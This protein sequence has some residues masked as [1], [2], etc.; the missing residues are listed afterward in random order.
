MSSG[1]G[2]TWEPWW[3][4]NRDPFLNLKAIIHEGDPTLGSDSY[5]LGHVPLA[6]VRDQLKPT[7]GVIHDGIVPA[8]LRVLEK[9]TDNDLVTGALIALAKIGDR[10]GMP[11]GDDSL[12]LRFRKFLQSSN[13][14]IAETAAVSLGILANDSSI[15]PLVDLL[16]DTKRGRELVGQT[17]V[18]W[19]TRAFAAY[20]L[21]LTG[22]YSDDL[23]IRA[24]ILSVLR[25]Q[26][27]GD[28]LSMATPDVGVACLTAMSL[29]WLDVDSSCL[30]LAGRCPDASHCRRGQL[31]W[32]L[33]Y[34]ANPKLNYVM[35]A[36]IPTT[37]ARL[38]QYTAGE[39]QLE[40]MVVVELLGWAR[41]AAKVQRHLRAS[42]IMALGALGTG[43]DRQIDREI[44]NALEEIVGNSRQPEV[45]TLALVSLG[46]VGARKPSRGNVQA[47]AVAK[48]REFL[49]EQFADGRSTD[50]GWSALALSLLESRA[51][52]AGIPP[53]VASARVLRKALAEATSPDQVGAYAIALGVMQDV[54]SEE[55]MLKKL[56]QL[57]DDRSRGHI[58]IGLGLMNSRESIEALRK[59]LKGS[60]YR[61]ALLREA[62]IS[63]GLLGDKNV[64]DDLVDEMQ[65]ST[66]LTGQSAIAA[67]LGSI[68]DAR[69]VAPLLK[70]LEDPEFNV[71]ARA[72]AAVALGIVADK[73]ALPWNSK[74]AVGANYL[75][76]TPTLTDGLG[77]GILDIL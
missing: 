31:E 11:A 55:L 70:M 21:G 44:I 15:E 43:A 23:A 66:S 41:G 47:E 20:G 4:F 28:A 25:G 56:E 37:L 1:S 45:R 61:P 75:A 65:R 29:V 27:E 57:S 76:G 59:L 5:F 53:S 22:Y 40:G 69:S 34:A 49:L 73:E 60:R 58:C 42:A 8:L 16:R 26:L 18:P 33:D 51:R 63:L 10:P 36:H 50:R 35:H 39:P 52:Q 12:V 17:E 77:A 72:F 48:V 6:M 74:I 7:E 24:R 14:E 38:T 67:A 13:Q 9:E 2:A 19:R 30:L 32:L 68:G 62:A 54:D 64:V 46:Q 3:A 71:R